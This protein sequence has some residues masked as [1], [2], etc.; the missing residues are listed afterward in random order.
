MD[1]L[2]ITMWITFQGLG[3]IHKLSTKKADLSTS[4][5][6][7]LFSIC[8]FFWGICLIFTSLLMSSLL[9]TL[10][11]I[12]YYVSLF[13]GLYSVSLEGI[14]RRFFVHK[15]SRCIAVLL[16]FISFF[17][18]GISQPE[19]KMI[20]TVPVADVRSR[21]DTWDHPYTPSLF[22]DNPGQLSQCLF[23]EY[24]LG[25]PC[26]DGWLEVKAVEQ[27]IVGDSGWQACPG[28]MR[29]DSV[30]CV[31][32]YPI[33]NLVVND[34]KASVYAEPVLQG[35]SLPIM[36]V[37]FGT[38]FMG[39]FYNKNWWNVV[40]SDGRIGYIRSKCAHRVPKT[41]IESA[42][43]FRVLIPL[44]AK[45]FLGSPYCW[46][47]RSAYDSNNKKQVT[48]VDCSCLI[49]LVYRVAGLMIPR[50]SRSQCK[51]AIPVA[52][53]KLLK[54]GD[55]IFFADASRVIPFVW[56]V[57]LYMGNNMILES[58]GK[59]RPFKTRLIDSTKYARLQRPVERLVNGMKSGRGEI[60]YL[61][62]VLSSRQKREMMRQLFW[63]PT[64]YIDA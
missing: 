55:L 17:R 40:F 56:H 54:P 29:A 60:I 44:L 12:I 13:V 50:N 3:L 49:N 63:D 64:K 20:V 34:L 5:P 6:Q 1:N 32:E 61:G 26:N 27:V 9:G 52:S 39:D 8:L 33:Q 38:R 30:T 25:K 10:T 19:Q 11:I 31:D 4:Y 36:T 23:N 16:L 18:L 22:A 14:M 53:G 58:Q 24:V 41:L 21:C 62:S 42:D 2:W 57:V 59:E 37:S 45:Q 15:I 48:S 43:Y 28:F 47:G 51:F 7:W 46:G 35:D